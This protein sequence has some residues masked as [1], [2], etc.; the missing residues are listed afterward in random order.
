MTSGPPERRADEDR[1]SGVVVDSGPLLC[2]GHVTGGRK[3]LIERYYRR[4]HW[5]VAVFNEINSRASRPARDGLRRAQRAAAA[6]WL[7]QSRSHL[8]TPRELTDRNAVTAM[9]A[10]VQMQSHRASSRSQ[11]LGESETLVLAQVES[12]VA[13]INEDP[14]RRVAHAVGVSAYSAFD[15]LVAAHNEGTLP[16]RLIQR[17]HEECRS[18]DLDLGGNVMLPLRSRV[19]RSWARPAPK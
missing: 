13:L 3:L 5:T 7:G 2:F 8:G 10:R 14:A 19:L 9:Q 12:F 1:C 17:M 6:S 18:A 4:L 11:D 16:L 15:V